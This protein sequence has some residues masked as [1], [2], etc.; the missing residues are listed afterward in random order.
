MSAAPVEPSAPRSPLPSALF[1]ALDHL[2][3]KETSDLAAKLRQELLAI[4]HPRA[5][6]DHDPIPGHFPA[7]VTGLEPDTP[8][9][10]R[11]IAAAQLKAAQ[12]AVDAANADEAAPARRLAAAPEPGATLT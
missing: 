3:A 10:R 4:H 2:L 1:N 12:A 11:A 7:V 8:E 5:A 9:A 6:A